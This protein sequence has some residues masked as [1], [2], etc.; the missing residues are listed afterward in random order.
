MQHQ[1]SYIDFI[2]NIPK[3]SNNVISDFVYV[4]NLYLI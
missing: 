1:E 4:M 3:I 2:S